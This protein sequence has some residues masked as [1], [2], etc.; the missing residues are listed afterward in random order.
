MNAS[1]TFAIAAALGA[2]SWLFVPG[3]ASLAQ[4]QDQSVWFKGGAS[5]E[6]EP[7]ILPH[8]LTAST[9]LAHGGNVDAGLAGDYWIGGTIKVNGAT[10]ERRTGSLPLIL[11]KPSD[12]ALMATGYVAGEIWGLTPYV[13][14]GVGATPSYGAVPFG[15]TNGETNW[16]LAYQGVAGLSFNLTPWMST[17]VEYR[18]FATAND[19][20]L[21][22]GVQPQG[23]YQSHD[24]MLRIDF[25]F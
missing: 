5:S 16:V 17:G 9:V 2:A 23:P 11:D 14:A 25:G 19:I 7:I 20:S 18:Y 22:P 6:P 3:G 4:Q 1:H 13:G 15:L 24:V 8:S 21:A 10:M 12:S